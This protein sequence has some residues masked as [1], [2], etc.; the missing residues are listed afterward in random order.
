MPNTAPGP[1]QVR[2]METIRDERPVSAYKLSKVSGYSSAQV[3]TAL[4]ALVKRG[5]VVWNDGTPPQL[6][7]TGKKFLRS[8][9]TA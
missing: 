4:N 8:Q 7:D 5:L 3:Q 1:T 6:T 9:K 2:L